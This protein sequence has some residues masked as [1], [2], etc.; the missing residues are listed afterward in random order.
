M[1]LTWETGVWVPDVD[2]N[3][4][5]VEIEIFIDINSDTYS[6]HEAIQSKVSPETRGDNP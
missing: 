4:D 6:W 2:T 1:V 3:T 5:E